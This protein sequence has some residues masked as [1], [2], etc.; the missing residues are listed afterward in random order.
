MTS[1]PNTTSIDAWV[2]RAS[3]WV[4]ADATM[5]QVI[6]RLKSEGCLPVASVLVIRRLFGGSTV[7]AKELVF[8]HPIWREETRRADADVGEVIAEIQ[9]SIERG[10]P[11]E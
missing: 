11:Q 10:R 2:T 1:D 8:T 9:K 4:S 3:S 7:D 5:D 6:R